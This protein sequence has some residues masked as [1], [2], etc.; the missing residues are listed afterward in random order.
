MAPPFRTIQL[1]R[2]TS[3]NWTSA[4]TL[5]AEGELG[6]EMDTKKA[7]M[8]DWIT[9]WNSLPYAFPWIPWVETTTSI[10]ELIN[11]ATAKTTPVDADMIPLM[12]SAASNIIKKLSWANVKATL[13][14]YFDTLYSKALWDADL[15]QYVITRTVAAN[16][17]TVSL[18]NYEGND[19][20]STKPIKIMIGWAIRTLT[21]ASAKFSAAWTNFFNLTWMENVWRETELFVYAVWETSSSSVK[22]LFSRIPYATVVGDFDFNGG[23]PWLVEKW[24]ESNM[25][26]NISTDPV[27]NIWKFNIILSAWWLWSIPGTSKIV[28]NTITETK[29][30]LTTDSVFTVK[31][32]M[33]VSSVSRIWAQY[34]IT[35]DTIDLTLHYTMTF[36]WTATEEV[37][38]TLP[39]W[40][41]INNAYTMEWA[42]MYYNGTVDKMVILQANGFDTNK[43]RIKIYDWWNFTLWSAD[44]KVKIRG[45]IA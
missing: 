30:W 20:T 33:T 22:L 17:L 8:G 32:A 2:D 31:S 13:K 6:L 45:R 15:Y 1:Q 36:W 29:Y 11:W 24:Y 14:T 19:A 23:N 18:K 37:Y 16:A 12:D 39:M 35:W 26:W 43:I 5:L 27:V 28:N 3:A 21:V 38:F 4:N 9:S 44:F 7:K 34:K 41:N 10:W 42:W 25:S 40:L